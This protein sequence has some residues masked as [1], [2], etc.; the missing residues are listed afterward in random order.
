MRLPSFK[1]LYEQDFKEED[2]ALVRKLGDT[3]NTDLENVYLALSGR[4]SLNDNIQCTIKV[5][6]ITVNSLGKPENITGYQLN[7]QGGT[8][9]VSRVIGCQIIKAV[10][11]TNPTVYPNGT[12]FMTFTQNE[13]FITIEHIAGLP[14]NNLFELTIVAYN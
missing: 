9:A 4:I 3:L 6:Q 10:N 7:R 2:K 1:R 11:L 14:Q 12:P 5:L 8:Q 13:D